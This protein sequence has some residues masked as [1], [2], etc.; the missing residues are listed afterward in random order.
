[1]DFEDG[2]MVTPQ[3][4][5]PAGLTCTCTTPSGPRDWKFWHEGKSSA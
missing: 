1:M 2:V 3:T 4:T 5:L